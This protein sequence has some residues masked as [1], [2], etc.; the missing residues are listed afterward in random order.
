M[1]PE[2]SVYLLDAHFLIFRAYHALPAMRAPDG[3]PVGAVRGYSQTLLRLIR[4]LEPGYIA[5]AADFALTSFRNDLYADYKKG[6]TE[7]PAELEPQFSLCEEVTC[8]LGIPFFSLRDFEADDV[9]AT[10]VKRLEPV[11]VRIWIITRDKDLAVLVSE[12]VGLLDPSSGERAG[13]EAVTSRFGVPP[14]LVSDYL[15]LVGDAA[16]RVPGVRGIGPTAARALLLHFGGAAD[17]SLDE[18]AWNGIGLR[19]PERVRETLR[20]GWEDLPLW[21]ELVRLRD[22]LPLDVDLSDLCYRGADR[23]ELTPLLGRLGLDGL[24]SRVPRWND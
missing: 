14:K 8:A 7:A 19:H 2:P 1:N 9:I 20:K 17:L 15:A 22:D 12:S 4:E 6:R 18:R 16:D 13:P 24:L 5:A 23:G 3:T 21:R 10:L 11:G